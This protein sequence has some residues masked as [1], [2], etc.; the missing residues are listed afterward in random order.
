MNNQQL[1]RLDSLSRAL[2]GFDT[3]FDQMERRYAN[4]VSNNYPP[5]NILKWNEDQYEIQIAITG[6]EKEEIRVEV[7]Q[8]QL[9][10]Y[11]ESKEMSLG[12]AMYIHRGLA[13][14]DFE[15]TFTLAEHMEVKGAATKN[16]MLRIQIVR[17]IPESAK[18]KIIDIVEVK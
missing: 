12:D 14:R 9:T 4:S 8:N 17:N 16:G 13:T 6:F 10:V 2:I 11:G 7:E 3:M 1:T 18:P 15:R 5:F